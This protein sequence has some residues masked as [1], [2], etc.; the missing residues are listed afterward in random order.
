MAGL[1]AGA[2]SM[3]AGEYVSVSSQ[4]DT[5][6]ADIARAPN[7]PPL[8]LPRRTNSPHLRAASAGVGAGPYRRAAADRPQRT[9]GS[10]PRRTWPR[11][12]TGRASLAGGTRVGRDVRRRR[13]AH[14]TVLLAPT[15]SMSLVVA[16]LHWSASP[17]WVHWPLAQGA[18][19]RRL[20][21]C[22]W[23]SGGRWR[24]A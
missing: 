21:P 1:V 12:G 4:A 20:A 3:A 5:E 2:L 24:W 22:A 10:R 17:P 11:R 18:R 13:S 8:P 7:S 9:R 19:P 16:G 6:G 15:A 23:P 14:L